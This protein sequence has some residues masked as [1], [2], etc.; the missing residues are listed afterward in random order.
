MIIQPAQGFYYVIDGDD[1]HEAKTHAEALSI[2]ESLLR[3]R[4]MG[5]AFQQQENGIDYEIVDSYE[6]LSAPRLEF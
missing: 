5:E 2:R 3:E 1:V 4:Q 6:E